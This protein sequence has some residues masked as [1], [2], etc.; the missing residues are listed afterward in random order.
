MKTAFITG[1]TA[2]IGAAAARKFIADG[3]RV[4]AAG[5][6]ADRLQDLADE[7]GDALVPLAL[8]MRDLGGSPGRSRNCVSPST[9]CSIM[10]DSPRR[11]TRS[12][13][14]TSRC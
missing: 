6:R 2:G 8:D 13:T 4:I 14:P 9:C 7:L 11:W 5:R 12:R 3:W 1:A 10:P